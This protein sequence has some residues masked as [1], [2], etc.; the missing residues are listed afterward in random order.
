[1]Q[2]ESGVTTVAHIIQVA[3]APVFLL[4]AIGAILSVMTNRLSRVVDRGRALEAAPME[5][6]G[7]DAAVAEEL[8]ALSHRAK[9]ISRSITLYTTTA[10]LICA[11]IVVLFLGAFIHVDTSKVVAWMFIAAMTAFFVGLLYF[12]REI[13]IAEA[14]IRIGLSRASAVARDPMRG[15]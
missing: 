14:S 2:P 3:V 15:K 10:L 6:Q 8:K 7:P 12:L 13:F 9:L 4:S 1:M 11:V 5:L